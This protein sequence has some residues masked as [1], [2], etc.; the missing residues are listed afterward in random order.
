[1]CLEDHNFRCKEALQTQKNSLGQ[2]IWR[3]KNRLSNAFLGLE[4]LWSRHNKLLCLIV[5]IWRWFHSNSRILEM[6]H[7]SIESW[8]QM[9][10]ER[11][12]GWG[13]ENSLRASK[14][15]SNTI[16]QVYR[17]HLYIYSKVFIYNICMH[18]FYWGLSF[19]TE[20]SMNHIH[21]CESQFWNSR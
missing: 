1:M 12:W 15:A 16:G 14:I 2:H 17:R 3:Y 9:Q 13:A 8:D 5:K 10:S 7:P 11:N 18:H 19:I 21:R 4:M 20:P 6:I